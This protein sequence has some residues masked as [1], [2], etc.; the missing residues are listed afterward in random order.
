M[1][2]NHLNEDGLAYAKDY[3]DTMNRLILPRLAEIR[4]DSTV[5]GRYGNPLFCSRYDAE[6]PRGTVLILHGF[7]ECGDKF[8]ELIHSLLLSHW[9]VVAYDQRGHGRSWR[10]PGIRDQS[11][12]HV[13]KFR[14]YIVDLEAVCSRV[15]A[16]MPRP[17]M[18]FA[19]SMG[20]AVAARYLEL[21]DGETFEKAVLCAPMIACNRGGIPHAVSVVLT[22]GASLSGMGKKRA[23]ISKPYAGPDDFSSSCSNCRERFDWYEELRAARPELHTNGPSYRWV[24]NALNITRELLAP[25]QPE[26]ITIPLRL[27]TAETDNQVLPDAQKK[28]I[29]RVKKGVRKDVPGSRH[30]IYRSVDEVVFP[31]WHE[32]LA[33]FAGE[34]VK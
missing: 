26:K 20:G 7:T 3:S 22:G 17:W 11:L 19:H 15:L 16:D 23:F 12:V 9:S 29:G 25:G 27:Y 2:D 28:F 21:H 8:S 14:D 34:P 31:W 1:T 30:E 33:F 24:V 6:E 10:D 13:K 4:R 18:I 32:I 5:P